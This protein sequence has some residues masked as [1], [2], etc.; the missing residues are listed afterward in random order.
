MSMKLQP[1]TR[2]FNRQTKTYTIKHYYAKQ[3]TTEALF[4]MLESSGTKPKVKHK[5]RKELQLRNKI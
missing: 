1:S 3:Y 5:V 2:V 4:E